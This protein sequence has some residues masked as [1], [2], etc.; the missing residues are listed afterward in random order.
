MLA[1]Y[2]DLSPA[3][4]ATLLD[5]CGPQGPLSPRRKLGRAAPF[6]PHTL[7]ELFAG[8]ILAEPI[9]EPGALAGDV[10]RSLRTVAAA[11]NLVRLQAWTPEGITAE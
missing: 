4:L 11:R 10:A 2:P 1:T 6:G 5:W 7:A 3:I 8:D 9:A